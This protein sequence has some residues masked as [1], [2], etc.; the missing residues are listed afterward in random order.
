MSTVL[1]LLLIEDSDDD[2]EL[3]MRALRRGGYELH[4]ERVDDAPALL[5]AL[6]RQSWDV[7]TCDWVMPQLRAPRA[8]EIVRER[9]GDAAVLVV[10]GEVGEEF[11]VTAMKAGAHDFIS[12]QR[13][14]RLVP[15]VEREL[16]DADARRGRRRAEAALAESEAALRR[17]L[18]EIE[19]IYRTAPI[20]LAFIDRDLRYVRINETLA[21]FHGLPVQAHLGRSLRD[22]VPQ[23]AGAAERRVRQV[24]ETGRAVRDIELRDRDAGLDDQGREWRIDYYPVAGG[25]GV[26][27]GV[28]ALVQEITERK[29]AEAR[30]RTQTDELASLNADLERRVAERTAELEA[31]NAELR[32]FAS[33][34]S[35]D[36]RAPLRAID[37]FAAALREDCAAQLDGRGELHLQRIA[38][39]TRRMGEL[40]EGL[41]ALSSIAQRPLERAT[42]DLSELASEITAGLRAAE[43]ARRVEVAIAPRVIAAGDPVLLHAVL[44][45]LLDNAW[46]FTARRPV[47]HVAFGVLSGDADRV[48]F[49]RDDG[50]GFDAAAASGL[51]APFSRLHDARDFPGSGIGLTTVQRI[52]QRHGG[53]VWAE[54]AVDHGATFYFTLGA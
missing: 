37:G 10:S 36:L 29:R 33:A 19:N 28:H 12:K 8:L 9:G 16:A 20:G 45:N 38:A 41:L 5:A 31:A 40:I 53:R 32:A 35:H 27:V 11:A 13:L 23:I 1:R 39:A 25:D 30:L 47:A 54:G 4:W 17:E 50:A 14:A 43:P 6:A 21:R 52:I 34:V 44:A 26:T 7:I 2:A 49:V 22:V 46:K 24:L 48:Y 15:A 18:L 51:F 42:V 3:I